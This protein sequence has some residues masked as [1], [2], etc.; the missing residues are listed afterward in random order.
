MPAGSAGSVFYVMGAV[1]AAVGFVG[2]VFG[3]NK[4]L[5]PR[6]PNTGK[7]EPYE[8]GMEPAGDPHVP[9]RPRYAAIAVLF[10]IFD[11]ETILLFA[12]ASRL[13]G[14]PTAAYAVAAFSAAL[15]FGLLY[16]W[17]KGALQWR[18]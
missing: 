15:A 13:H 16:A 3:A 6:D 9:V 4:L 2:L 11:A 12:V 10:V 8:C 1:A 17:R 5:S 14:S 18:W 7:S